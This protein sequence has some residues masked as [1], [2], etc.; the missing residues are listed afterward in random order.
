LWSHFSSQGLKQLRTFWE[1]RTLSS[2]AEELAHRTENWRNVTE[3]IWRLLRW[4]SATGPA[5]GLLLLAQGDG[6]PSA[7]DEKTTGCIDRELVEEHFTTKDLDHCVWI[8][9]RENWGGKSNGDDYNGGVVP[10]NVSLKGGMLHLRAL[11]NRYFGHVRGVASSKKPRSHGRRT[12]AVISTRKK[13]LG[14]T[15]EAR[16]KIVGQQGVCSAMWTFFLAEEEGKP[17]RNHE[18]DIEFPGR[19]RTDAPPS[20]RFVSFTTW[21]GLNPG[22]SSTAYRALDANVVGEFLILRFDWQPPASSTPGYVKFYVNGTPLFETSQHVPSEPAPFLIGVWF[23]R[24]W[25]GEPDFNTAEMLVDWIRIRPL[26]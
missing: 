22:E 15:F 5:A 4:L 17:V 18:I 12:G 10:E 14:G 11:G 19:E 8:V 21:T 13:F 1:L 2:A 25:A 24:R 7:H 26:D 16:V 20:F 23:P 3:N 6:A 9:L